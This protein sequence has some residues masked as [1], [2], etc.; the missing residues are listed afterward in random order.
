[1]TLNINQ[2]TSNL[3]LNTAM[4]S[5][6]DPNAAN[7]GAPANNNARLNSTVP[8]LQNTL[9]NGSPSDGSQRELHHNLS[10]L[11]NL[12]M[13]RIFANVN[14]LSN[15]SRSLPPG[16]VNQVGNSNM[17]VNANVS[18]NVNV[19]ANPNVSRNGFGG[20]NL[21]GNSNVSGNQISPKAH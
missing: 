8:V 11:N 6:S 20:Q 17:P 3:I 10:V 2:A 21:S 14:Q 18:A 1:M 7:S 13:R 19:L 4:P 15:G 12:G 16:A 5:I 9:L